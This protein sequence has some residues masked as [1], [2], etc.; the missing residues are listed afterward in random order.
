MLMTE[1][2]KRKLRTTAIPLMPSNS[3]LKSEVRRSPEKSKELLLVLPK[4]PSSKS[5]TK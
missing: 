4:V 5:T 1:K 2:A 3:K